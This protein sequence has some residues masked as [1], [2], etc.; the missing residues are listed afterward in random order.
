M[1]K[2]FTFCQPSCPCWTLSFALVSFD[3]LQP[4]SWSSISF[5]WRFCTLLWLKLN[6]LMP[7]QA[8]CRHLMTKG[9]MW[10]AKW[11]ASMQLTAFFFSSFVT[12]DI[13]NAIRN[14]V[15]AN[16]DRIKSQNFFFLFF[17]LPFDCWGSCA[18]HLTSVLHMH[19]CILVFSYNEHA[20]HAWLWQTWA[21]FQRFFIL[22]MG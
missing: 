11:L 21:G 8:Y 17:L 10:L 16:W 4:F 3:W 6:Y 20:L 18:F 12:P 1:C 7:H 2:S 9:F 5:V 14:Q 22:R 13:E 15:T 19:S